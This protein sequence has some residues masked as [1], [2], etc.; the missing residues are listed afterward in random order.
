ME[1]AMKRVRICLLVVVM[2]AVIVGILYYYHDT[3]KTEIK[4]EGTLVS[5]L[6]S[7]WGKQCL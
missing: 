4:A 5:A 1:K 6:R 7:K 3:D 2:V